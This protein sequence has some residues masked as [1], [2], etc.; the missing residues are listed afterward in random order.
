MLAFGDVAGQSA[1]AGGLVELVLDWRDD[2]VKPAI[3]AR[4]G[5]SHK[6]M[7]EF[8]C[9]LRPPETAREPVTFR[10]NAEDCEKGVANDLFGVTTEK[11]LS[12]EVHAGQLAGEIL[13]K[14]HVAGLLD[15]I[16][17]TR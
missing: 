7:A 13:G 5:A 3:L 1:K 4:R 12:G 16:P 15:E 14:D 6:L 10:N 2:E 11:F 9:Y 17:V 8:A